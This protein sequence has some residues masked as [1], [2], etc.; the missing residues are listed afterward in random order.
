[1]QNN[2]KKY[3][4]CNDTKIY[5]DGEFKGKT[6][7]KI[8]TNLGKHWLHLRYEGNP[9]YKEYGPEIEI[10]RKKDENQ[11]LKKKIDKKVGLLNIHVPNE[12]MGNAEFTIKGEGLE[13]KKTRNMFFTSI[14]FGHYEIT[15]KWRKRINVS[16]IVVINDGNNSTFLF[17]D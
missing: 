17:K 12:A 1:M 16:Y 13:I 7:K 4:E 15:G 11:L 6:P 10:F 9:F 14:P 2:E 5:L 8:E 3:Q